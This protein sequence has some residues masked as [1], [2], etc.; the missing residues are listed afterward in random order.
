MLSFIIQHVYDANLRGDK[1]I[2]CVYNGS[3][4]KHLTYF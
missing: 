4:K 2:N 1:N 3:R